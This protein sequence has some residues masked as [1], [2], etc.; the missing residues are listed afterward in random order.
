MT[1]IVMQLD[2]IVN[3]QSNNRKILVMF[4]FPRIVC[5]FYHKS[6]LL[7]CIFFQLISAPPRNFQIAFKMFDFN[8]DGEV[9]IEEF[10]KARQIITLI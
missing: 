1:K 10:E 5:I 9:D 3:T 7:N 4:F 8:G 2:V 6:V